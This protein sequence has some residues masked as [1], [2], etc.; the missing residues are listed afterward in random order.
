MEGARDRGRAADAA[1][2]AAETDLGRSGESPATQ[3]RGRPGDGTLLQKPDPAAPAPP[4]DAVDD[5]QDTTEGLGQSL[6]E[7]LRPVGNQLLDL[8][9]LLDPHR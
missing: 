3:P 1:R 8:L 4:P 7:P 2:P 5:L 6:G 9:R